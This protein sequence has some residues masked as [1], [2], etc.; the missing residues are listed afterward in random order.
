[1]SNSKDIK[2]MPIRWMGESEINPEAIEY[3][4]LEERSVV[5]D[6]VDTVE[7]GDM[8]LKLRNELRRARDRNNA[9]VGALGEPLGS[10]DEVIK[11]KQALADYLREKA[12]KAN[13]AAEVSPINDSVSAPTDVYFE[14]GRLRNSAPRLTMLKQRAP[15]AVFD[16]GWMC[17]F[18]WRTRNPDIAT[19]IKEGRE[20]YEGD[21]KPIAVLKTNFEDYVLLVN[22]V[23]RDIYRNNT[24]LSAALL[25]KALYSWGGLVRA[26]RKTAL[27]FIKKTYSRCVSG[28]F[29]PWFTH[30]I[31]EYKD[32]VIRSMLMDGSKRELI[33][34]V[35]GWKRRT[36]NND[37]RTC[38]TL[39]RQC[40]TGDDKEYGR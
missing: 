1:M 24:F 2:P 10:I 35:P 17:L 19:F 26:D 20:L 37:I 22:L 18:Q 25:I 34:N 7:D 15:N 16:G 21:F 30:S 3:A 29:R 6:L 8:E 23:R 14:L 40:M 36:L 39:T 9:R 12:E 11:A 28:R 31:W 38:P 4:K 5:A 13:A 33:G 27:R 32:Q